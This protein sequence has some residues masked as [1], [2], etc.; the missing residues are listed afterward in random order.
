MNCRRILSAPV[1]VNNETF[2]G[3]SLL[4]TRIEVSANDA[5]WEQ[6]VS[7]SC[8]PVNLTTAEREAYAIKF[9]GTRRPRLKIKLG[10]Y[11]NYEYLCPWSKGGT[12]ITLQ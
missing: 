6:Y 8:A 3:W 2:T 10:G 4:K 11:G 5:D 12:T 1:S 9:P 7:E